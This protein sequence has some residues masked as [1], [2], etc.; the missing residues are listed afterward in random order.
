MTITMTGMTGPTVT[1]D[2]TPN[3]HAL[4]FT[5][6]VTVNPGPTRSYRTAAA[7]DAANDPLARAVFALPGVTGVMVLNDFV[8]VTKAS[9][10]RWS[11]LRPR[12]EAVL[13][14]HLAGETP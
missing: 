4:K 11:R 13:R 1:V 12:V 10:A 7:A 2:D 3:P 6:P 14:Q 5:L 8:T 9:T